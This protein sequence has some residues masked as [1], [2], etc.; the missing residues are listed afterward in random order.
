MSDFRLQVFYT[1]A[2]RLNFTRAAEELLITQPAV[3]RHIQE[4]ETHYKTSLFERNGA[5]ISLTPAGKTLLKGVEELFR[6]YRGIEED[7][8]ALQQETKGLLRIGASTTA[9]Q[10]VLPPAVAEMRQ[11]FPDLNLQLSAG[12][13]E[14]IEQLLTDNKI[15]IG[16]VEGQSKRRQLKYIP[17][18]KDELVLC[19]RMD[20]PLLKSNTV[21]LKK[22]TELPLL[23]REHGSG[24][25]EVLSKALREKKILLSSLHVDMV[26]ESTESIK[27]YLLHSDCF[28]FV[29][30]HAILNELK[31]RTL[32]I[33]D[34][35]QL[36]IERMFHFVRRQG[37]AQPL[38]EL[39]IRFLNHN[40]RL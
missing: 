11:K 40:L 19:T 16:I 30:I 31:S 6:V 29:S 9:A 21:S 25:L 37:D 39:L 15:D 23:L 5:R 2:R 18:L 27:T 13:T 33:V 38:S 34:V 10:Y 17:Y 36:T 24:T 1:A 8:A 14:Q 35:Q 7:M 22:L 4:L 20:N 12:N 26:L 3:T 28:A 32:M